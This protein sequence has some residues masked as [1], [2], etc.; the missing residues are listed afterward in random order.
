M[1]RKA[2]SKRVTIHVAATCGGYIWQRFVAERD[3]ERYMLPPAACSGYMLLVAT[4]VAESNMLRFPTLDRQV[5]VGKI[6]SAKRSR[7]YWIEILEVKFLEKY[8]I[9]VNMEESEK[10]RVLSLGAAVVAMTMIRR[11]RRRSRVKRLW[12]HAW[13]QAREE[14]GFYNNTM[15]RSDVKQ[16]QPRLP[17]IY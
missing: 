9:L 15:M 4:F 2:T 13:L 16:T 10:R 17:H 8:L 7:P 11:M 6:Y 3:F 5:L 12:A 1:Y 14:K